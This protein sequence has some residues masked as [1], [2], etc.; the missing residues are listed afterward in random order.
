M[1]A[2]CLPKIY[3]YQ[4]ANIVK[5]GSRAKLRSCMIQKIYL[6]ENSWTMSGFLMIIT[7]FFYNIPID[8][9]VFFALFLVLFEAYFIVL[10]FQI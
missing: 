6:S 8:K 3:F 7:V 1:F 9:T 5:N 10:Q 2:F 4:V